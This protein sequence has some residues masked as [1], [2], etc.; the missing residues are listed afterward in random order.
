M[1]HINIGLLIM[2]D[3]DLWE[4]FWVEVWRCLVDYFSPLVALI[5]R[6]R[7]RNK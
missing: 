6:L 5:L 4:V 3:K 7:G 2:K 1:F